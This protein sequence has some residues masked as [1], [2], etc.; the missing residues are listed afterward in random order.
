[1]NENKKFMNEIFPLVLLL[2]QIQIVV[3]KAYLV[4]VLELTN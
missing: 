2:L 1:M 3:I 4:D